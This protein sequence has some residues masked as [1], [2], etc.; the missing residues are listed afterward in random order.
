MAIE[1]GP[2]AAA[3]LWVRAEKAKLSPDHVAGLVRLRQNEWTRV[4]KK[5][6]A[7]AEFMNRTGVLPVKPASWKD[8]FFP[9]AQRLPGS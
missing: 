9:E 7:Y 2:L 1:E 5:I 6:M 3:E 4:P 8:V